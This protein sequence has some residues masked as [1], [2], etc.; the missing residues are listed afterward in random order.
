MIRIAIII[1]VLELA[2]IGWVRHRHGSRAGGAI[3][4]EGSKQAATSV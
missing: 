4:G 1:L 3:G 2:L